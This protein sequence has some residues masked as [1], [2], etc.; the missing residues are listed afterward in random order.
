MARRDDFS[1]VAESVPFDNTDTTFTSDNVQ[2]ALEEVK[3]YG[4]GF[5]R[6]GLPLMAN[7]VVTNNQW[8]S[9]NELLP[10]TPIGPWAVNIR[11]NELSW[12]NTNTNVSF[13][14][15]FY[16]NGTTAGDLFYTYQVRNSATGY[17]YVAGLTFDF[18]A[19]DYVR[20]K[21]VDQGTN[22]ADFAVILWI[23]RLV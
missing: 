22:C 3:T 17:G 8:I 12:S 10:N 19:G 6:A 4:E 5:P 13:D 14:L 20:I 16:K 2:D 18:N 9:Y 23:S 21:Y 15:L 11:L 7:G 1:E